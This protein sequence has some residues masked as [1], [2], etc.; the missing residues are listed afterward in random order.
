M[1]DTKETA[2][3]NSAPVTADRESRTFV[4][5]RWATSLGFLR[6]YAVLVMF[7]ALFVALSA[8]TES[9][10]TTQNLFNIAAQNAPLAIIAVAGTLVII[11][12]GFDLSTGSIFGVASVTAAWVALHVD[13]IIG[14]LTAPAVGFLLGAING[15]IVT[16][17]KV[18]SFLAT[19]AT[20]L[21]FRGLATLI[22]GGF[23]ISVTAEKFTVI[24]R[25]AI[26]PV[27]Y[28][29]II[30]V[31]FAVL[32]GLLLNR[33][34]FGRH[35][36]AVGGNSEAAELS[37]VRVNRIRLLTFALSG[38]A[39]GLAGAVA[40]SRIGSG[41]P[42]AGELLELEAIA[43]VILGGTSIYGG[44]GAVWRSVIGV[45]LLALIDNGFNILN[46]NPFYKDLTTGLIIVLAVALS[47]AEGK[48]R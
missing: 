33:T 18:H 1:P 22:T 44:V 28:A 13:P 41:Q 43:A 8:S 21:V 2:T 9:F 40:V 48:R 39:A 25:D 5:S 24:G 32:V 3:E 36:F 20:S 19:L 37:G 27:Y 4:E 46:A 42:T 47:A 6:R 12:G 31:I 7:V 11:A 14:L 35:V 26:G 45:Y 30:F 10:L 29:V 15:G 16:A 34:V 17:L 38:L 23:L